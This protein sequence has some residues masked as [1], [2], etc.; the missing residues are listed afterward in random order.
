MWVGF[1]TIFAVVAVGTTTAATGKLGH[2][3]KAGLLRMSIGAEPPSLDAGL[4]TD[5]TSASI[6]FNVMDPLIRLG[7]GPALKPEPGA[8]SSWTLKGPVVT[9]HLNKAVKWTNGA[10]T[11]AQD[12]VYSW[13]RTISPQL[14]A[15]YAYQFFGIK[16]AE[17]YNGC[18]P[19]KADCNALKA[20]V[21]IKALNNSTLQITLTSQQPWFVQQLSHTSFLPVYKPIVD[22]YGNK[23]TEAANFIGNGPF[24][25]ASWKHDAS[26]TLVKNAK[27]RLANTVKLNQVELPIITDGTTAARAFDAGN[28]DVDET[29]VLPQDI[30]KYKKTSGGARSGSQQSTAGKALQIDPALGTYYYGFNVKNIT[31]VNQRRAMAF[32]IDRQA[33]TKYITQAGQVPAKGFTPGGIAGG[34]TIDKNSFMPATHQTAKAKAFMAKVAKPKTN[35]NLYLNNAPGHVKIAT[36]IQAFWKQIGINAT[37]KVQEWKQYL[38]FLGPPPNSDVD[39]YRS[40]WIY[41]YPDAQNGLVLWTCD[42]GN[43]STNFCN[44]KFDALVAQASKTPDFDKRVA[45]YQQAEAILTGPTGDLPI[46]PIYWYTSVNLVHKNVKGWF[47]GPTYQIDLTKVSSS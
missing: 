19:A 46:M 42:S 21:G 22:K 12:Y 40:G 3:S 33:I 6:L 9:L 8:A 18:D 4:A 41:D 30:P 23:F 13:L 24:K 7:P 38:E 34:P 5:T 28:I 10:P 17:A 47:V 31:D 20:A 29:G 14:G 32:A 43:N 35:I 26:L 25:L 15:D 37:I 44:K 11:T 1:A 27:W 39:V 16:G 2:T 45:L 36:A